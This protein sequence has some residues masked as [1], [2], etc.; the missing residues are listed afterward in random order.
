V[1]R[2]R[3]RRRGRGI[4]QEVIEAA[5]VEVISNN[6]S[7]RSVAKEFGICHISLHRFCVK[8]R[9][10]EKSQTGYRPH[11][12]VFESHQE[13][14]LRDYVKRAADLYYGL[15]TRDLRR[16]AYQCAVHYKLKFPQEW[17][18][19]EMAGTDWLNAF[20]KR[21]SSISI[22]RPEA[23]SLARALMNFNRASVNRFFY[24]FPKF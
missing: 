23:T 9:K 8:L 6:R 1:P 16:L 18:K 17:F 21:N 10:N 14:M 22:R 13:G 3:V 24:N 7:V 11:N 12:R 19:T 15:S 2:T 4:S 20:L 5:T